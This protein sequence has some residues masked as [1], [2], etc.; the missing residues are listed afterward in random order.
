MSGPYAFGVRGVLEHRRLSEET[1][2]SEKPGRGCL[3]KRP[4]RVSVYLICIAEEGGSLHF[5]A[6]SITLRTR[7]V[8]SKWTL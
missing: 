7:L 6:L 8:R 4:F 1:C 2:K 3:V 5:D